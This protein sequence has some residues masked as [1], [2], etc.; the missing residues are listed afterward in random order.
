VRTEAKVAETVVI[1]HRCECATATAPPGEDG[2]E[3]VLRIDG[4]DFP[5]HISERGPVVKRLAE[6][7]YTVTV[8]IIAREV[9]AAGV[10]VW[11]KD[12]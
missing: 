12:P 1:R 10:A 3:H 9:D 6:G 7:S 8:E 2:E 5:W 11:R 4:V